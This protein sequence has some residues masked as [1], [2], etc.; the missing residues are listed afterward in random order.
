M[1]GKRNKSPKL[2]T[3]PASDRLVDLLASIL[4][5]SGVWNSRA[6]EENPWDSLTSSLEELAKQL[7]KLESAEN[8]FDEH[9]VLQHDFLLGVEQAAQ[10]VRE[11]G[12]I[13]LVEIKEN[14]PELALCQE[15]ES[16]CHL[17]E[18]SRLRPLSRSLMSAMRHQRCL[19]GNVL[20]SIW[21][22]LSHLHNNDH[23]KVPNTKELIAD[24]RHDSLLIRR[25][26][27][28][29]KSSPWK[30]AIVFLEQLGAQ[31]Q[32]AQSSSAMVKSRPVHAGHH[33]S[34][35]TPVTVDEAKGKPKT[36]PNSL[37]SSPSIIEAVRAFA[38]NDAPSVQKTFSILLV[39]AE[40]SGKTHCCNE[41]E[42]MVPPG[43][44]GKELYIML[45]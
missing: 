36:P 6:K 1:G 30:D 39:G 37:V 2:D 4:E 22:A 12:D 40:G 11:R 13:L 14:S 10:D 26:C 8:N 31:C 21:K 29:P 5:C 38:F 45:E 27:L 43:V 3:D 19:A 18:F 28:D 24:I 33:I 23:T 16:I 7:E 35:S 44:H 15:L 17:K 42:K 34:R 20:Q 9:D 41:I 32:S 25:R